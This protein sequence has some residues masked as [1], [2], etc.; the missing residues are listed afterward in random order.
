MDWTTKPDLTESD[1]LRI[2]ESK[3]IA[4]DT[5]T[6]GLNPNRDALYLIQICDQNGETDILRNRD[7][8]SAHNIRNILIDPT[9]IKVIQFAIM[10]CGFILKNMGVLPQNVYCTKIASKLA[11]TYAPSHSLSS[12]VDELI[13]V[14]LDKKQQT[15]FWGREQLSDEQLEYASK[16]VKWLLGIKDK[17]ENM[18]E[19]KGILPTGI[20]YSEL[21][22]LCQSFIPSLVHLWI[23]GWDYGKEDPSSIFG[24]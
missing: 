24:R 12:L 18:L 2:R 6:A 3:I 22:L 10:D 1:V 14:T 23:N 17:L 7:W 4:L 11:R 5:E 9:I 20:S 13:G 8:N 16:D 19:T 21:N 15:T